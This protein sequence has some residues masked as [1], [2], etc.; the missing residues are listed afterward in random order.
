M[1]ARLVACEINTFRTDEYYASTPPLEA[2]KM[3]VSQLA[4]RKTHRNGKP[5]CLSFIDIKKRPTSMGSDACDS[6]FSYPL[7]LALASDRLRTSGGAGTAPG[8]QA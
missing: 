1:R 8:T 6:M 5:L 4:T 2:K 7:N 3:L